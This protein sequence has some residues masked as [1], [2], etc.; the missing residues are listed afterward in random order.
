MPLDCT[1]YEIIQC[2]EHAQPNPPSSV[3]QDP[4]E[5]GSR[6]ISDEEAR[7]Q[8]EVI[9]TSNPLGISARL[10]CLA[11]LQMMEVTGLLLLLAIAAPVAYL[12]V[13]AVL[14]IPSAS[15]AAKAH[16]A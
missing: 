6:R 15:T 5:F 1:T 12:T 16:V 13:E 11:F 8:M 14:A 2:Y 3:K 10:S 4:D 9:P 7:L